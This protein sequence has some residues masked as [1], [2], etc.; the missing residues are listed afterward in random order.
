[1]GLA[2]KRLLWRLFDTYI[3]IIIMAIVAALLVSAWTL[4]GFYHT[5][6]IQ[7]LTAMARLAEIQ[8]RPMVIGGTGPLEFTCQRLSQASGARVTVVLPNGRVACDSEEEA[9]DMANH[10]D[11]PEIQEALAMRLGVNTRFSDTLGVSMV[12][13]AVPLVEQGRPLA[14]I[15]LSMPLTY[16]RTALSGVYLRAAAGG[17]GIILLAALMALLV[18]RNISRPLERM[19][20]GAVQFSQG[21]L[22]KK[23]PVGGSEELA[24]LGEAMNQMAAQLSERIQA[25]TLQRNEQQAILASMSEGVIAFNRQRRVISLNQ[26]ACRMLMIEKEKSLG[27][28]IE[29]V[30]RSSELIEL[31]DRLV[32]QG[33]PQE[34]EIALGQPR[35]RVFMA[36]GSSLRDNEG[37]TT[38]GV[39]VLN[40]ITRLRNLEAVRKDFVANVSHEL[41]TPLTSIKGFVETLMDGA[42]DNQEEARR[43][44]GI[45][46]RQVDHMSAIIEDLLLLSK[47]ERETQ[48]KQLG[49]EVAPLRRVLESAIEAAHLKASAKEAIIAL[50][51]PEELTARIN[52]PLINQ[53]VINLLDNA[54]SYSPAGSRIQLTAW[55]GQDT[56]SISV[57]DQGPGIENKHQDRL[58]ERFYR[59][60]KARSRDQGGTGLGLA[61]VKHIMQAHGGE[62]T[63]DS[64][65]GHGSIFTLT[66]PK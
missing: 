12:Y 42:L 64:R 36:A 24:A 3:F 31:A 60:D 55:E 32:S 45:I 26:A 17:L 4:R 35:G 49:R 56:V 44:L 58:F 21:R 9:G 29:E 33:G 46:D 28:N 39:V 61:I 59:V 37:Q 27:R 7:D 25:I 30:V 63:L 10:A 50:E 65:L 5:K 47:T 43:F 34:T 1:M 16:V 13:V 11:R 40:D 38:G 23:L 2:P 48:R 6:T 15:R 41:R 54:I 57:G 18:S 14:A 22:E 53:A 52:A 8:L 66:L 20:A 62:V 19:R 51:C